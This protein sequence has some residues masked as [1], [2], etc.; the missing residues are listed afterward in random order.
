MKFKGKIIP[1]LRVDTATSKS[2]AVLIKEEITFDSVPR[3]VIF[4]Y[5]FKIELKYL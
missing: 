3:V 4:K 2:N 5:D 1:V